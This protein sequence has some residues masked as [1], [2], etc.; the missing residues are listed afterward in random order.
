[1]HKQTFGFFH[2]R[3]IETFD[4]GQ[5]WVIVGGMNST[6]NIICTNLLND[7]C[8]VIIY[9]IRPTLMCIFACSLKINHLGTR[10][11]YC[12]APNQNA[13]DEVS[14]CYHHPPL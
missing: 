4:K 6:M 7:G 9:T 13:F 14:T 11:I 5:Q 1:M 3:K 10:V 2:G 12:I 8:A